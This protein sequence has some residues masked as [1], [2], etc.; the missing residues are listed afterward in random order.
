[1]IQ[2]GLLKTFY[3]CGLEQLAKIWELLRYLLVWVFVPK[4][5]KKCD[6]GITLFS[7][8][9]P[10]FCDVSKNTVQT[11]REKFHWVNKPK[12]LRILWS[13]DFGK[14]KKKNSPCRHVSS[15]SEFGSNKTNSPVYRTH[16]ISML[17][18]YRTTLA[19]AVVDSFPL[20]LS[21]RKNRRVN[22]QFVLA[23][24]AK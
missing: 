9:K 13:W 15:F 7:L 23:L 21:T 8:V 24:P 19:G 5:T 10:F 14:K 4:S 22:C 16:R 2:N 18:A 20:M 3:R 6:V 1:M 17:L 11:T 12:L